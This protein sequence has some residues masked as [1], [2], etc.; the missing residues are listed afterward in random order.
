MIAKTGSNINRWAEEEQILTGECKPDNAIIQCK[1]RNKRR[2][3][4]LASVFIPL[5]PRGIATITGIINILKRSVGD[6][7]VNNELMG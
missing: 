3:R 2:W 1:A 4:S 5:A 6:V 7:T